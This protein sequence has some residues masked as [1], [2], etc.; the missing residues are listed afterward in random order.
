[1][2]RRVIMVGVDGSASS[3]AALK[4]ALTEA[5]RTGAD[6]EAVL[7]WQRED[8]FVPATSMGIHPYREKPQRHP[9]QELHSAVLDIR[10][11]VP[12]APEVVETTVV[13]QATDALVRASRHADLLVLGTRGHG[14]LAGAL[15]GSVTAHCIKH[16][17]CPVVVIPPRAVHE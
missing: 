9:A 2:R 15:L 14:P 12:S 17:E 16:A 1:M 6:V 10:A 11:A 5:G 3:R 4:W 7:A 8:A 13:S